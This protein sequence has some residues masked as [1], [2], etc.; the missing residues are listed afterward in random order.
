MSSSTLD[1]LIAATVKLTLAGTN[2]HRLFLTEAK[3]APETADFSLLVADDTAEMIRDL[4]AEFAAGERSRTILLVGPPG[5]GKSTAARQIAASFAATVLAVDGS[6][7]NGTEHSRP[8]EGAEARSQS[9]AA[10][11]R[12][13][14]AGGIVVDDYDRRGSEGDSLALISALRST[15]RV[16]V[17]TANDEDSFSGAEER[18][19]RFDKIMKVRG[20]DRHTAM[21]IAPNLPAEIAEEAWGGLLAAYLHELSV[22]CRA[23]RVPPRIALDGL[24]ERQRKAEKA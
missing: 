1:Q 13:C 10:I 16:I 17:F 18:P 6:S 9:L 11:V 8:L 5:S 15:A 7:L 2:A 14:G 24:L 22:L 12:S 20:L 4:Q 21:A 19:G 23:G 3:L